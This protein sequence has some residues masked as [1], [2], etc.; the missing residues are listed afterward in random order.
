MVFNFLSNGS[1]VQMQNGSNSNGIFLDLAGQINIQGGT[2]NSVFISGNQIQIQQFQNVNPTVNPIAPLR[3]LFV[4]VLRARSVE[5][6]IAR[7]SSCHLWRYSSLHLP[8]AL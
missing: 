4:P 5:S 3:T 6:P 8:V 1:N 2:H 7:R